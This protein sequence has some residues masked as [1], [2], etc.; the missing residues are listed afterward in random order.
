M[1]WPRLNAS[2]NKFVADY[3]FSII[4]AILKMLLLDTTT[5]TGL[6]VM[7]HIL[8]IRPEQKYLRCSRQGY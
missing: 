3:F 7:W 1:G 2:K 8:L 6:S 4:A 5:I